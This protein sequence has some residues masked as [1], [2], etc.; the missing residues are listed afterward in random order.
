M[1]S[2]VTWWATHVASDDLHLMVEEG[3][4]TLAY[5]RMM[6]R[7]DAREGKL[8]LKIVDTV[9][10]DRRRGGEGIGRSL[11]AQANRQIAGSREPAIGLLTCDQRTADFYRKCGWRNAQHEVRLRD[12][13]RV[14]RRWTS[15]ELVMAYDPGGRW[16]GEVIIDDPASR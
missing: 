8:A 2:Q 6:S 16:R 7:A 10:V 12:A 9:C 5:L 15:K 11:M 14:T 13:A 1:A 4:A 3:G